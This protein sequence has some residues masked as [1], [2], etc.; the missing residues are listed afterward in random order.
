MKPNNNWFSFGVYII[1]RMDCN[2]KDSIDQIS[3]NACIDFMHFGH[4]SFHNPILACYILEGWDNFPK[5]LFSQKKKK[6][7][8]FRWIINEQKTTPI[9][10]A[11]C[12]KNS[13]YLKCKE[14]FVTMTE[15]IS[16][17]SHRLIILCKRLLVIKIK[18]T[19]TNCIYG[20]VYFFSL[21]IM[22]YLQG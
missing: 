17:W 2:L 14:I 6:W 21:L 9:I 10:I 20:C 13:M 16:F 1:Y 12:I 22:V 3:C 18:L 11:V 15:T 5:R 8:Q 7:N 4:Y 19:A